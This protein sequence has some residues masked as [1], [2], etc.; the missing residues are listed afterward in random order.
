MLKKITKSAVIITVLCTATACSPT[1][2]TNGQRETVER[3][4]TCISKGDIDNLS[5]ICDSDMQDDLHLDTLAKSFSLYFNED[6]YGK[7]FVKEA[8]EFKDYTFSKLFVSH[9]IK[10]TEVE[11]DTAKVKVSGEYRDFSE[12]DFSYSNLE[13]MATDYTVAHKD[14]LTELYISDG[15]DAMM[16]KIYTDIAP[17]IFESLKSQLNDA[18]TKKLDATFELKKSGDDWLIS[19]ISTK[20]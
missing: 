5:E 13:K 18:D 12:L 9:E 7:T 16:Q 4:F 2:S 3:F 1:A 14:E 20:Q 6:S 19:S 8:E 15:Y 10:D 11:D 17:D